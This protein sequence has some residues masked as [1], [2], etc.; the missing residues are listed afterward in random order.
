MLF[1]GWYT[2][3]HGPRGTGRSNLFQLGF[4][5]AYWHVCLWASYL[6][7]DD[8]M[9]GQWRWV[10]A[11]LSVGIVTSGLWFWICG[12]YF[13]CAVLILNQILPFW[14]VIN[15][16]SHLMAPSIFNTLLYVA[17]MFVAGHVGITANERA[18]KQAQPPWRGQSSGSDW[19][20]DCYLGYWPEGDFR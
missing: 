10:P 18:A 9:H 11:C 17:F 2:S 20:A 15:M 8:T 3:V 1:L 19:C 16:A 7:N 12:C 13:I 4:I 14:W 6:G 5:L